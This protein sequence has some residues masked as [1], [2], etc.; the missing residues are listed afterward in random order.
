MD[1][2]QS[3][4]LRALWQIHQHGR[5]VVPDDHNPLCRLFGDVR[6]QWRDTRKTSSL[7]SYRRYQPCDDSTEDR[8]LTVLRVWLSDHRLVDATGQPY[9]W[10]A[11]YAHSRLA[12]GGEWWTPPP[13]RVVAP[14]PSG[15]RRLQVLPPPPPIAALDSN[16]ARK[17]IRFVR[18]SSE[19]QARKLLLGTEYPPPKE[20]VKRPEGRP[21]RFDYALIYALAQYCGVRPSHI[22]HCFSRKQLPW[23]VL[24]GGSHDATMLTCHVDRAVK[25]FTATLFSADWHR[26]GAVTNSPNLASKQGVTTGSL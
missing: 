13:P 6:Q 1:A 14:L 10:L 3:E 11:M 20:T 15:L 7:A 19:E 5:G 23:I 25:G 22:R 21:R 26:A 9:E 17:Y 4:I 2:I 24:D 12:Y 8:Q 18:Q 16:A